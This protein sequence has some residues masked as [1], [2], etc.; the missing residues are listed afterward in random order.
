[1]KNL[2]SASGFTLVE[3]LVV[4][5]IIAVIIALSL[6]NYLGAR[7]RAK[8]ARKKSELNSFKQ[9]LRLYYNDYKVYPASEF[10]LYIDGCGTT[11]TS[12]CNVGDDFAAGPV[13]SETVYM[14]WLP[15]GYATEYF[16]SSNPAHPSDTDDF[17]MKVVLDNASDPDIA[18]SQAR[19]GVTGLAGIGTKDYVV[20][21]D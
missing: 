1:M 7:Q 20:C 16:Y 19:C 18:A 14:K 12:R 8:D 3:M 13:G 4:I 15:P 9:A 21:A 2:K 17:L 6:P 5:S 11:G 10:G